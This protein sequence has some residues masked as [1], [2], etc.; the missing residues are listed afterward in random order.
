MHQLQPT[1]SKNNRPKAKTIEMYARLD[2]MKLDPRGG[3][4]TRVVAVEK[5]KYNGSLPLLY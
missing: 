3:G 2:R 1:E 4:P 5:L